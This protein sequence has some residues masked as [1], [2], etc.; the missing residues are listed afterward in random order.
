MMI[1]IVIIIIIIKIIFIIIFTISLTI[2]FL[3]LIIIIITII[4]TFFLHTRITIISSEIIIKFRTF[5]K[6]IHFLLIH[7]RLLLHLIIPP[8]EMPM[9]FPSGRVYNSRA[10]DS[11]G[12][13][14]IYFHRINILNMIN[15]SS[16]I[17][18][19]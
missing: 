3:L 10:G 14:P 15:H 1:I 5:P 11:S 9:R 12:P 8:S 18:H 2:I 4:I 6:K 13:E 16:T 7:L 19:L 17:N